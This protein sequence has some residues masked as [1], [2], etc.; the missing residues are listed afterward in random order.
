[1][2][3]AATHYR[4]VS[5][6]SQVNE[7][8]MQHVDFVRHVLGRF[9]RRL[10]KSTDHENLESAGIL[11]LVEAA[12]HYDASQEV[13]FTTFAYPRVRGAILDEL[14][15]NSPLPQDIVKG[16]SKLRTAR[17]NLE[18]PI[19]PELLAGTTG[20]TVD[21]VEK[22]LEAMRLTSFE[23]L[24][25]TIP[26]LTSGDNRSAESAIENQEL[27][28]ILAEEIERLPENERLAVTLYYLEDMRLK[29]IGLAL[30][31]T[32]SGASR[33]VARAEVRLRSMVQL[34]IET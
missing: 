11:G 8:V 13:A 3:T 30:G 19:T 26:E 12:R 5:K 6:E 18:P 32:E 2:Q 27:K 20:M 21:D 25:N 10:P 9:V 31:L 14:R 23:T 34:R 15:R 16:I 28:S 1:M 7:L 33:L 29:E 22:C 24:Q 4:Q 17:E